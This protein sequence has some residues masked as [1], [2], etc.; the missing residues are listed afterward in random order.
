[1]NYKLFGADGCPYAYGSIFAEGKTG[2]VRD[3]TLYRGE[4]QEGMLPDN[5]GR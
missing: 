2:H 4:E 3:R 1:V 5:E